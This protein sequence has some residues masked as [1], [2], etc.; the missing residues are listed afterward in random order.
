MAEN[1]ALI[2]IECCWTNWIPEQGDDMGPSMQEHWAEGKSVTRKQMFSSNSE[3][4][5]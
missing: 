5:Y 2:N 1:N 3:V 4:M